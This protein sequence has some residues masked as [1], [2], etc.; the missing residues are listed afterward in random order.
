[1]GRGG[2]G[3]IEGDRNEVGSAVGID[4]PGLVAA[5]V[6]GAARDLVRRWSGRERVGRRRA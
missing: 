1:L 3:S 2:V 6:V 4:D 5:L